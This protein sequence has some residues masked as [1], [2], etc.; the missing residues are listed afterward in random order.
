[1]NE[2]KEDLKSLIL[3][4]IDFPLYS[5]KEH[6]I[7]VVNKEF[8]NISKNQKE[9]KRKAYEDAENILNL[10]YIKCE[11]EYNTFC[12]I[13][14]IDDD[15]KENTNLMKLLYDKFVFD[16]EKVFKNLDNPPLYLFQEMEY[17]IEEETNNKSKYFYDKLY[18]EIPNIIVLSESR[19][20]DTFNIF[21][22]NKVILDII[23]ILQKN[24]YNI[25]VEESDAKDYNKEINIILNLNNIFTFSW[26][27]E[28]YYSDLFYN[29]DTIYYEEKYDVNTVKLDFSLW[30]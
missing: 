12:D 1:M 26:I 15:D 5:L 13:F 16:L 19:K 17:K 4:F 29:D 20:F 14:E 23:K 30:I 3:S 9:K 11:K 18:E 24:G 21:Q 25:Y 7:V 28:I 22:Q 8:Y 6:P 10:I 27:N 2:L